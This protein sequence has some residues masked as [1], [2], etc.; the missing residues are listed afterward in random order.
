[1]TGTPSV[2]PE[3]ISSGPPRQ[4]RSASRLRAVVGEAVV[5]SAAVACGF[6]LALATLPVA[7]TPQRVAEAFVQARFDENW[8]RAW[9]L[10]CSRDQDWVD[11]ENFAV[12]AE[13]RL[14]LGPPPHDVDVALGE[15]RPA[16]GPSDPQ[17]T[18]PLTLKLHE[19]SEER[20]ID[21]SIPLVAE[22]GTVRV[23]FSA[24]GRGA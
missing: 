23:C 3:V 12:R 21:S 9:A 10:L 20:V 14:E 5:T 24:V 7:P 18:V 11:Y 8:A 22:G 13:R 15:T 17:F 6:A 16:R 1:M 2:I 4:P 19:G